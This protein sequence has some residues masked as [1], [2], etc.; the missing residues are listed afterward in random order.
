MYTRNVGAIEG[1]S[2]VHAHVLWECPHGVC[3][4]YNMC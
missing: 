2:W 4:I 1:V 3:H